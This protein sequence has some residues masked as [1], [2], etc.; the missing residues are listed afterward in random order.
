VKGGL[1]RHPSLGLTIEVGTTIA[2]TSA[3][4][5]AKNLREMFSDDPAI[6]AISS[7]SVLIAG[8]S[9]K[10]AMSVKAYGASQLIPISVDLR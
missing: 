7:V 10:L 3:K 6:E 2:E 4:E 5:L 8:G 9:A 1:I